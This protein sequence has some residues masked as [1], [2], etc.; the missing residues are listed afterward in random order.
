MFKANP[1]LAKLFGADPV[2]GRILYDVPYNTSPAENSPTGKHFA[3]KGFHLK[4]P[5]FRGR[6]GSPVDAYVRVHLSGTSVDRAAQFH[7]AFVAIAVPGDLG[8]IRQGW[9]NTGNVDTTRIP[10]DCSHGVANPLLYFEHREKCSQYSTSI[11][12]VVFVIDETTAAGRY[13][14]GNR[15]YQEQWYPEGI[16]FSWG[17]AIANAPTLFREGE[18]VDDYDHANWSTIPGNL[19]T[20]REIDLTAKMNPSIRGLFYTNQ[21]GTYVS[22]PSSPM[23]AAPNFCLAQ[24]NGPK[25]RGIEGRSRV[26]YSAPGLTIPN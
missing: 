11:R 8:T 6:D 23:C 16:G 10:K 1:E 4:Y 24:Y 21:H 13:R 17:W 14:N 15:D 19:G 18:L 12:P 25:Y 3:M 5:D 20:V 26:N 9:I 2:T 22:S 7:S